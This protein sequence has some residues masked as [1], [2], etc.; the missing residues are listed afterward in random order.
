VRIFGLTGGIASGKSTVAAMLRELGAELID[1]DA[2]YHDLIE[3][4]DGA[5][6]ELAARIGERF[7]GVLGANGVLD[8][9]ALGARVFADKGELQAL[10]AITHP[11]VAAESARRVGELAARGVTRVVY[12]VPLLYERGLDKGMEG[13]IVVWVPRA[14]QLARLI[15]RDGISPDAAE[16][17]LASQ[18]PLDEKRA[19]AT[20]VVDNSGA[21]EDTRRQV[22]QIWRGILAT[23]E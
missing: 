14:T 2:V 20:W 10:G 19:R 23:P 16:Q 15:P 12:D 11:A 7:P 22:Q 8:R 18:L 6:S 3:P 13:V 17:R 5:P 9:R 4:K 21:R 1:A